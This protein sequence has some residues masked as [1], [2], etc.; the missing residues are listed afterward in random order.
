MSG[1]AFRSVCLLYVICC[2]DVNSCVN[3]PPSGL[4][5]PDPYCIHFISLFTDRPV[6][7]PKPFRV[8]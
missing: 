2:C 3:A 4:P 5:N 6:A 8:A 1:L 7:L